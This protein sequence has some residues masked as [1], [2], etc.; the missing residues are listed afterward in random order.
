MSRVTRRKLL[1]VAATAVALSPT[2]AEETRSAAQAESLDGVVGI[3]TGGLNHQREARMLTLMKLPRFARDELG[4]Q[5][6][7]LNTRWLN[8]YDESY[9]ADARGAAHDAGCFFSNLK[10]NH[11]FGDLYSKDP[12]ERRLAM[13]N[14]RQMVHA[15]KVLGARWI[16]F[17][18]PKNAMAHDL[19]AHRELATLARRSGMQ[20][21]V[22]NG[23]WMK[24]LPD[25]IVRIVKAIGND[26]AAAPDT[27]NWD[28]DV[29]YQAIAMSFPAAVTCDFKVFELDGKGR[30]EK[31][32]IERCFRTAWEAGFR[33]PWAIEHWNDDTAAFASET[34]FLR[35]KLRQWMSA[36]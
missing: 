17:T 13:D 12:H 5:L 16:R 22:E 20:L 29:R 15:A 36:A 26:A 10:V 6:I 28:D 1:G 3:T 34:V 31:Y 27:G 9:L 8:S 25:S 24:S 23:G 18:I 21:V 4:M 32:D 35:D 30:H 7:D 19:V 33:G 14:G 2:W 11:S